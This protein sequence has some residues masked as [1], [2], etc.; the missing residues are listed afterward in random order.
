MT[1]DKY[2]W[3]FRR[4]ARLSDYLTIEELLQTFV[5]T[6]SCGGNM[7]M[8]VG[9]PHHGHIT[10]IYEERLRQLGSW[11]KVN[12][13]GIYKSKPWSYQNDTL[14]KNVWYT[15]KNNSNGTDV[16]AFIFYWPSTPVLS[17]ALPKTSAATTIS[18]LGYPGNLTFKAAQPT[19]VAILVPAIPVNKMPCQWLWV[20]KITAV[21]N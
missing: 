3:G 20:F 11:L 19:G 17:L 9:P 14:A 7:L 1:I 5:I 6:V 15:S 21:V 8:N 10:P 13:D 12:G 4:N 18:L 16:Y 2:S